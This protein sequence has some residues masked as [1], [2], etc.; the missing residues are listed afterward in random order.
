VHRAGIQVLFIVLIV[1]QIA[2]HPAG[3][4]AAQQAAQTCANHG[5]YPLPPTVALRRTCPLDDGK[6][7][8]LDG[9]VAL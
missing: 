2:A 7:G 1:T 6:C 5:W 9:L 3:P 4:T 8:L